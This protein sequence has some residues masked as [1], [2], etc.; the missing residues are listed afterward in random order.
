MMLKAT[1]GNGKIIELD[2]AS[3][4]E[5][6]QKLAMLHGLNQKIRDAAA[7]AEGSSIAEK[8]DACYTVYDNLL[9]GDWSSRKG[10]GEPTSGGILFRALVERKRRKNPDGDVVQFRAQVKDFLVGKSKAQQAELRKV[11]E[12]SEIILDLQAEKVSNID[13][14]ALLGELDEQGDE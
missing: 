5:D 8:Y 3:L 1:F 12:I 13:A 6:I 4:D 7:K 11:R 14:E 10:G 9:N 2:V